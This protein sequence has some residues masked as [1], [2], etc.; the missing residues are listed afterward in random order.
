MLGINQFF[1]EN[2]TRLLLV[3]AFIFISLLIIVDIVADLHEGLDLFHVI[4]ELIVFVIAIISAVS[5]FVHL[6]L[7]IASSRRLVA[8]L[9]SDLEKN[10]QQALAWKNENQALLEGLGIS[11]DKQFEKWGLSS[12]EKEIGLFLL[13]GLSHKEVA[14]LRGVSEATARQQAGA[15]YKKAGLTGRHDLAAFFLED[16]ALPVSQD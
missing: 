8:Q 2:R 4:L 9:T 14:S 10:R 6:L 16:L 11:I 7:E 3:A 13:K 12:T 1:Y 5:I 15:I